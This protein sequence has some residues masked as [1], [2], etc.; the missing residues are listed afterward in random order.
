M[1]E[2]PQKPF[3]SVKSNESQRSV[4]LPAR[5]NIFALSTALRTEKYI[6]MYSF[7]HTHTQPRSRTICSF[8]AQNLPSAEERFGP[9]RLSRFSSS[10]L[11]FDQLRSSSR[12]VSSPRRRRFFCTSSGGRQKPRAEGPKRKRSHFRCRTGSVAGGAGRLLDKSA[13]C[14]NK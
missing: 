7:T 2:G 12:S 11:S 4:D 3:F 5:G 13:R 10:V 9:R 1:P 8:G 14:S 6:Q